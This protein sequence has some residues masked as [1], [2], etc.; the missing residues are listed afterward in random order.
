MPEMYIYANNMYH[1]LITSPDSSIF[2]WCWG[3]FLKNKNKLGQIV[4][5][6]WFQVPLCLKTD[7]SVS[8]KDIF[9]VS[10]SSTHLL[11][12]TDFLWFLACV[13]L[14]VNRATDGYDKFLFVHI[15][16]HAVWQIALLFFFLVDSVSFLPVSF[17]P[18]IGHHMVRSE[19]T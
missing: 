11:I 5:F 3:M 7:L 19:Q 8:V 18:L 1:L 14:R 12:Q 13:Y 17:F 9:L 6:C 2:S 15:R 16:E 10:T 4:N